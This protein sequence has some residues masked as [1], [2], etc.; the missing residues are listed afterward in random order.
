MQD[1]RW[2]HE[3]GG[4][5]S[6][7]LAALESLQRDFE[8]TAD[9]A[10]DAAHGLRAVSSDLVDGTWQ[11]TA[12]QAFRA[13]VEDRVLSDLAALEGSYREAARGFAAYVDAVAQ[14]QAQAHHLQRRIAHCAQRYDEA[15]ARLVAVAESLGGSVHGSR[16]A[17][18]PGH[19]SRL[20]ASAVPTGPLGESTTLLDPHLG[21]GVDTRALNRAQAEVDDAWAQLRAAHAEW[22]ALRDHDR[23]AADA[24]VIT[25]LDTAHE[26]GLHDS[27]WR[28]FWRAVVVVALVL[29]VAVLVVAVVAVAAVAVAAAATV[30]AG[31]AATAGGVLTAAGA[32]LSMGSATGTFVVVGGAVAAGLDLTAHLALGDSSP[33][34]VALDL[35]G[36]LPGLG[37][38][39]RGVATVGP[40]AARVVRL[41]TG[42]AQW[43]KAV[44]AMH[45]NAVGSR[46]IAG[47][48][49]VAG[50]SPRTVRAV[51]V[52]A[53]WATDVVSGLGGT[54]VTSKGDL[55]TFSL[56]QIPTVIAAAKD[57][58]GVVEGV[59]GWRNRRS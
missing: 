30:L 15:A 17:P 14:L 43:H 1:D 24:A 23:A 36:V 19:G 10:R 4:P 51:E 50:G 45:V 26:I 3:R 34:Q 16:W 57:G 5:A 22:T 59:Q 39:G 53:E 47:V 28:T 7:D 38:I 31:G 27:G 12:A 29:S 44:A 41:A 52:S 2:M 49:T 8:L 58:P 46:A 13:G 42:V 21:E 9:M 48:R 37:L 33:G 40:N 54:T 35:I 25:C 6:G 20:V 56:T 32:A 11:G 18:E 55:V